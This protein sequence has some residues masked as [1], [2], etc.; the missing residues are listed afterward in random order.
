LTGFSKVLVSAGGR[1]DDD[2]W[3]DELN[4]R[5]DVLHLARADG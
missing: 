1:R 3:G 4:I 2:G 5:E